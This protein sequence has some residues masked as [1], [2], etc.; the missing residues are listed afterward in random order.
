[1]PGRRPAPGRAL[2]TG[3]VHLPGQCHLSYSPGR[4]TGEPETWRDAGYV[5]TTEPA[6]CRVDQMSGEK[7][8]FWPESLDGGDC[9]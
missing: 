2:S 6:G 5:L 7:G 8:R 3:A 4:A 1:M 9:Y